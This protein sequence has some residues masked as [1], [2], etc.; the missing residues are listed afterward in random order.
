VG[1]LPVQVTGLTTITA[2]ACGGQHCLALPA[3]AANPPV[4]ITCTSDVNASNDP[5]Q[6]SAVV[7]YPAPLVSGGSGN[8]VVVC[9]PSSGS[10]FPVGTTTVTCTATDGS[11][12][13]AACS[14]NVTVND[15]EP[16][17]ASC[18]VVKAPVL[19]SNPPRIV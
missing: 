19:L 6:C 2:I 11:G 3:V 10:T 13:T 5:G 9:N 14:F 1:P 15:T 18:A 4:V 8:V 7:N 12:A 17:V 16:P